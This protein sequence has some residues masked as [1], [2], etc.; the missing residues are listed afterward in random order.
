[1]PETEIPPALRGDIYL[2]VLNFQ[3]VI[4]KKKGKFPQGGEEDEKKAGM[5]SVTVDA[6]VR[7]IIGLPKWN[8]RVSK[9]IE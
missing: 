6:G 9:G 1:M 5:F 7:Y 4:I 8:Q 3:N 2:V